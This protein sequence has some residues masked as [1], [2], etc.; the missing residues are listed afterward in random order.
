MKTR[1]ALGLLPA[2]VGLTLGAVAP[3]R[4]VAQ[5]AKPQLTPYPGG[6]W[7]PGPA[8]YG[9][10]V[11]DDVPVTMEDGVVLRA[12]IA[13][14]TDLA[15][16]ERASGRFPVVIEH[17]PYVRLGQPVVPNTYLTEHGYIYAVVRARG[18]GSSGVEV[19]FFSPRDA[20]DGKAIVDW[21]AHR[22]DG[23]DGRLALLGCS[24]PGGLALGDAAYLGP[25][26]PVKAVVAACVGLNQVNRESLMTAGLM[27]TGFWNYTQFAHFLWGGTAAT[28]RFLERFTSE[29]QAGGDAAYERAFWRDRSPLR[30]AQNIHDT[31]IPVLLWTGWRDI[32]E[33]GAVRVYA[34]LQNAY[35]KR[36]VY[37]PMTPGQ[38]TTPRYQ[39]I[40][41]NWDHA[42][43][44]DAGIYLEWLE[45]WVK[46]VDTGI[47]KTNT[48]MHLFEPGTDR[49]VNLAG[50]PGASE[51]TSWRF[52][53]LGMLSSGA[54][55]SG[56]SQFRAH[57]R[58]HWRD[59]MG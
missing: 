8:K 26:S 43:G 30:W 57:P 54:P 39:I 9:S 31:G 19:E 11:I 56:A 20:L 48:P 15:T 7:E 37:A 33:V 10:V 22:L 27:T 13:Y 40:V 1:I 46:G 25:S 24:Y 18:T 49:W 45:T 5:A 32:V 12:S 29:V 23:S 34:A 58:W 44:L 50:F 17:T 16:K 38:P 4:A 47:Q 36:P 28:D 51:Y 41:G 14:P 3:Y 53:G 55:K 52:D 42:V 21:A 35:A 6:V 2:V 59:S